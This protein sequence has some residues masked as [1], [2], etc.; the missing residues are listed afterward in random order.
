MAR[1]PAIESSEADL[2]VCFGRIL[3]TYSRARRHDSFSS[4][5]PVWAWFTRAGQVVR[6][7]VDAAGRKGLTTR[8]SVG[9]GRWATVPWIA[10]MDER[11]TSRVSNGVYVVYLFR[12]DMTGVYATINQGSSDLLAAHKKNAPERLRERAAQPPGRL[13]GP[14]RSCAHRRAPR[15]CGCRSRSDPGRR[16]ATPTPSL[17]C[18]ARR[19]PYTRRGGSGPTHGTPGVA[20]PMP[21][22]TPSG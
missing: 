8:W 21:E 14:P 3:D 19:L 7:V 17:A 20:G 9:Q 6:E 4:E 12:G 2:D 13:A 22:H 16:A 18:G 5:H 15:R 10:V 1:H 11:E